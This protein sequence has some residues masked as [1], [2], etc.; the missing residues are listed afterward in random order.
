MKKLNLTKRACGAFLLWAL[1]AMALPAQTFTTLHNFNNTDGGQPF[2]ALIQAAD[3]NLY[4]TTYDGGNNNLGTVFDITPS[5]SLTSLYSFC[6]LANCPDG[7]LPRAGL[8]QATDGNLYG[9]T[10]GGG[11]P[12]QYGTVF[13]ISQNGALTSL[14][15]FD[16]TD[17][18]DTFAG[19]VQYANGTFYGAAS[20]GGANGDG[21]VFSMTPSGALTTLHNFS[22]PDGA[23]P[24]STLVLATDGNFYGTTL[25][26]GANNDGEV[27]R[28][29]PA[30]A[31]TVIYS[32]CPQAGCADGVYPSGLMQASDG[33]LYGTTMLGGTSDYGTV[34]K[35]TLGGALT[36]LYTFTGADGEN[37][38][39]G[40]V[41]GTDGNFYGTTFTGGVH[42]ASGT[43][44]EITPQGQFTK[45]YDFCAQQ[46]CPDGY[47]PWASLLQDTNGTFYGTTLDGGTGAYG[48]VFS[49][50]VGLQPFVKPLPFYGKVAATI[51]ILGT[52]LTGATSVTFNGTAATFKIISKTLI[53]AKVP[54]GATTGKIQ[55]NLPGGTLTSNV[56]FHVI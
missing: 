28:L 38:Q 31:L 48:T 43:I 29:T 54:V 45:L 2:G 4:G 49:L 10:S 3:G 21:T 44:F 7:S 15:D 22:G 52:N 39:S 20:D 53:E 55:V 50:S 8:L 34:F 40:V 24:R 5:G 37:P 12:S 47:G 51:G 16:F 46:N 17:G 13:K 1:A 18:Y 26:G 41:Q 14:H 35:M 42:D 32:F 23:D 27:F 56:V 36:T 25:T 33:N 11:L 19:L 9:T 30:G 6:A